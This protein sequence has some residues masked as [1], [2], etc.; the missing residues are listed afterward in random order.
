MTIATPTTTSRTSAGSVAGLEGLRRRIAGEVITADHPEYAEAR[1][2]HDIHFDRRPLA[3][4]RA[5]C[6]DDVAET[7][8]F[9]RQAGLPLAVRSGGHSVTGFSSVDG[10]VVIDLSGMKNVSIDA[11]A[12]T[13][14]V[15]PGTTSGDF[16][17]PA[18]AYGLAL[19][20]GDTSSVGFGGLTTGGGIGFM[21]RKYGLAIDNL[22]SA[23]V[24]TAEGE[25]V[26]A[27]E[28]ENPDLFWAIRGGGGN[29]GIITEFEFRLAPVGQVYGG[30][31]V[32]PATKEVVRGYLDY[33]ADA[34]DDLTTIT[35]VMHAPP[36][37]FIPEERVGELVLFILPVWTGSIEDGEKAMAPLR[38]LAEPVADTVA[39]MPYPVIYDYTA[40]AAAPHAAEV[41]SMFSDEISDETIDAILAAMKNAT[42]PFSMV[43]LRGLGGAMADVGRDETA[44]AHRDARYLTL[45]IGLWLD[46]N[47]DGTPHVE[48]TKDLW[49]QIKH[50]ANGVYVN[51]VADEG[52][53]RVVDAYGEA[54]FAKLA[55]I[56]AKWDPANVFRFNQNIPPAVE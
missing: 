42:S 33:V 27:S 28:T 49:D 12:R 15:Q 34:P 29:F 37:P 9:V 26:T 17:G 35:F 53:G 55:A 2:V 22:L 10:A 16:A 5:A 32:L 47:E 44:F 50:D 3:V 48:W 36:A 21:V 25:Q 1:K 39:P 46:E 14:L 51:F 8:R 4:V 13:A 54:T 20:T 23:R 6:A 19:S 45:V 7:V 56:K 30:A 52:P 11:A 41:R 38:A 24:V 43:N 31:L 18:H 40:E